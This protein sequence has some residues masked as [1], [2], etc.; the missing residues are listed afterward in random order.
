MIIKLNRIGLV[1]L[2]LLGTGCSL[3][4]PKGGDTPPVHTY[5]LE[6]TPSGA[7]PT[8]SKGSP[9]LLISPPRAAAAY[10]GSDMLYNSGSHELNAFALHRWADSPAHMLEPLL[11]S[12]AEHSGLFR[13]V[14][15]A[16]TRALTDLRLDSQLLHLRQVFG[17][18]SCRV[19]LGVRIDLIRVA[20]GQPLGGHLF[21]YQAPCYSATP[22]GGV[23]TA[24]RLVGRVM[25]ELGPVLRQLLISSR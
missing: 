8:A 6:W 18:N 11:L 23:R 24:N 21:D 13:V 5:I 20:S 17:E 9:S 15:P 16:G 12:A 14:V 1:I 7:A 25:E 4:L 19:E 22:E 3:P 2:I 10:A